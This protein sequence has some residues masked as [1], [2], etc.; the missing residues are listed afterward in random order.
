MQGIV[1]LVQSKM[2]EYYKALRFMMLILLSSILAVCI[3]IWLDQK[4]HTTPIMILLLLAYAI[5]SSFYLLMKGWD[6]HDG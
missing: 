2:K 6:K 5:G 3:G 4:F 1:F